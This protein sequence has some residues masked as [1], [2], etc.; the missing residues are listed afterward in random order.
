MHYILKIRIMIDEDDDDDDDDDDE[1]DTNFT[2]PLQRCGTF[3]GIY[4]IRA[5]E[6]EIFSLLPMA[7]K[8]LGPTLFWGILAHWSRESA[9][10]TSGPWC[11]LSSQ[12]AA[13]PPEAAT[14]I[15]PNFPFPFGK[16][17]LR[18]TVALADICASGREEVE[19]RVA[20]PCFFHLS[21]FPKNQA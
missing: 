2:P 6:L 19:A 1:D 17:E 12:P 7:K 10:C 8:L 15:H 9:E 5:S 16:I 3:W 4:A 13:N 18:G 20:R 14:R 21:Y 11:C